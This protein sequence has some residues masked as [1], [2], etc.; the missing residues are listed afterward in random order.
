VARESDR[1]TVVR[2][3][4]SMEMTRWQS[5]WH[6][7]VRPTANRLVTSVGAPPS[8]VPTTSIGWRSTINYKEI[9]DAPE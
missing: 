7:G 2:E 6:G 1:A 5:A 3:A 4:I 9:C 8:A